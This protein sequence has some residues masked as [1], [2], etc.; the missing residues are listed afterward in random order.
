MVWY[1]I[2]KEINNIYS[3]F[4]ENG[5]KPGLCIQKDVHDAAFIYLEGFYFHTA[6]ILP[7]YWIAIWRQDWCLSSVHVK[8]THIV[9]LNIMKVFKN[10]CYPIMQHF[11]QTAKIQN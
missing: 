11:N 7:T 9:S 4:L 3:I 5:L 1:L 6:Y 10:L 8:C 2:L